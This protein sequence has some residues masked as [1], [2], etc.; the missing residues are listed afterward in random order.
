MNIGRLDRRIKI[1]RVTT[2]EDTFGQ[3]IETWTDLITVWGEK[4]EIR[5]TE[6][7]TANQTISQVDIIYRIRYRSSLT[8]KDRFV[9]EDNR[10]FNIVAILE[11][12]RREGLEIYG[13]AVNE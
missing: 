3:P 7:W 11:I 9:D 1:Q 6:R 10:V 8:T 13:K 4:R 5:G 2:S 12:G